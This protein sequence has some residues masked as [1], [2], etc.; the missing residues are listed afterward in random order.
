MV[1][2]GARDLRLA[3][4]QGGA[5]LPLLFY[6]LVAT[7]LPFA[8]G[9]DKALLARIGGGLL[10]TAALLAALLPV[11]RLVAPDLASGTID[12]F[13]AR[14]ISEE[15]IG[16]AKLVAHWLSFGPPLMVATLPAAALLGLDGAM[17]LRLEAGL[18]LGTPGLAALAL[19]TAALTAGLRGAG[20]LAGIV[21][22]PLAIPLLIFGAGALGEGGAGAT[23][24]LAATC[25]L[26]VAGAPFVT[27]A[28]LKAGRS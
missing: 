10:W 15:A 24:L 1:A 9:P 8:I 3:W 23:K 21:M 13:V 4:A 19:A 7:L 27:G 12:Q 17:V 11:E 2:I 16:V 6:L 14:G 28:A 20:A 5:A 22:L 25:L 26:L 18:A